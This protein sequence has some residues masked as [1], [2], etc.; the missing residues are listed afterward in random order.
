[1]A[2][3]NGNMNVSSP[4]SGTAYKYYDPKGFGNYVVVDS[5]DGTCQVFAHLESFEGE[6]AEIEVGGST[7]IDSTDIVGIMGDT[8]SAEGQPHTHWEVRTS[9]GCI[10]NMDTG[11]FNTY[12]PSTVDELNAKFIDP[13]TYIP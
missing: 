11:I 9:L 6:L 4:V 13:S 1:M 3:S 8:G 5:S 10:R 7:T 2:S 12:Y